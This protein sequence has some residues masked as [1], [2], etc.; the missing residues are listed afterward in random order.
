MGKLFEFDE[1][2]GDWRVLVQNRDIQNGA[3]QSRHIASGAVISDKIG[4]NAIQ[5]RHIAPGAVTG[6]KIDDNAI[7][8]RHIAPDAVT[9]DKIAPGAIDD[10]RILFQ[11]LVDNYKPIVIN[12]DV[13]N[14]PDEEDITSVDGLLKLKNRSAALSTMG[15]KIL[16]RGTPLSEQMNL[17]NTIYDI[18]YDFDLD[19]ETLTIPENCVLKFEGGSLL[20]GSVICNDTKI[21]NQSDSFVFNNADITG[22]LK[23]DHLVGDWFIGDRDNA[24]TGINAAVLAAY[25]TGIYEVRLVKDIYCI[26]N[27][28][29]LFNKSRLIGVDGGVMTPSRGDYVDICAATYIFVRSNTDGIIVTPYQYDESAGERQYSLNSVAIKNV[30]V[31]YNPTNSKTPY[32]DNSIKSNYGIHVYNIHGELPVTFRNS[33]LQNIVVRNFRFG[34]FIDNRH[35]YPSAST[36][37]KKVML[38]NNHVGLCLKGLGGETGG[39]VWAN[40]FTLNDSRFANNYIG[41]VY[42]DDVP[43]TELIKFN[44]CVFEGNGYDYNLSMI[45]D[46]EEHPLD[47]DGEQLGAYAFRANNTSTYGQVI[48]KNCYFEYNYFRRQNKSGYDSEKEQTYTVSGVEYVSPKDVMKNSYIVYAIKQHVVMKENRINQQMKIAYFMNCPFEYIGNFNTFTIPRPIAGPEGIDRFEKDPYLIYMNLGAGSVTNFWHKY[49]NIEEPFKGD[50]DKNT[51]QFKYVTSF[52]ACKGM[53]LP[54]FLTERA[55]PVLKIESPFEMPIYFSPEKVNYDMVLDSSRNLGGIC[56]YFSPGYEFSNVIR[57]LSYLKT[58]SSIQRIVLKYGEGITEYKLKEYSQYQNVRIDQGFDIMPYNFPDEYTDDQE[59]V[60]LPILRHHVPDDPQAIYGDSYISNFKITSQGPTSIP[61]FN[62]K[63]GK[64]LTFNDCEINTGKTIIPFITTKI[65]SLTIVF[66]RCLI[67]SENHS[68]GRNVMITDNMNNTVVYNDCIV[69][70][71]CSLISYK[72]VGSTSDRPSFNNNSYQG[73][74]YFSEDLETPIYW[75]GFS[76]V[77]ALGNAVSDTCSVTY[78]LTHITSS[79]TGNACEGRTYLTVLSAESGYTMPDSVTVMMGERELVADTD[80]TY[81][82]NTGRL[83]ILGAGGS[84]GVTGSLEITAEA[85]EIS[86]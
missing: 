51:S 49:V 33:D 28:I 43:Q 85:Q 20:N 13:T 56:T 53:L 61:T 32:A 8:S 38:T 17:I 44:N 48:F 64:V 39:G 76:W 25:L 11:D 86:E 84:G 18:R 78:A 58:D 40:T 66:N 10:I 2:I 55:F 54:S 7:R 41:G 26:Y 50:K 67:Y 71:Y 57:L 31:N 77:D 68:E 4:D 24:D 83:K 5:S 79:I 19:G 46:T 37:W 70:E 81:D 75:N 62:V 72:K 36:D 6:D 23:N 63:G 80:Y 22:S 65:D 73:Y 69:G 3:I 29:M 74:Q 82:K 15:Y 30:I 42:I 14:A 47:V 9:P 52:F 16:R 60:N 21:V 45:E 12:G 59:Q 35:Y 34:I 27:P 1:H